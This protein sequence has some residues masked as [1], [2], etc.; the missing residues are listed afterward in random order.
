V[1]LPF[2]IAGFILAAPVPQQGPAITVERHTAPVP[3]E[4]ASPVAS[5]IAPGGFRAI[6][7]N[8]PIEIWV[9]KAL[10]TQSPAAA[11]TGVEEGTLVGALR[12]ASEFRDIRGRVIK[13]GLYTLRYGI[14]PDNGDHLG[15]SPHRAFLLLAPAAIDTSPA[16]RG[17]DGA[18]EH[19]K[20]AIGGSHPAV[21]SIDP[22]TTTAE[23]LTTHATELEHQSVIVEVPTVHAGTPGALRFGIVLVGRIEA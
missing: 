20:Q 16:P 18:I 6:V 12:L 2:F 23:V 22:L 11:W 3:T 4:L 14:Q 15:V 7:K 5:L 10:Q 19:S 13:P 17:H 1:I 9:V 8:V 21:L